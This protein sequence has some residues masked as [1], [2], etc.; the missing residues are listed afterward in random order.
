[1]GKG[2]GR[3]N[4]LERKPGMGMEQKGGEDTPPASRRGAT[5]PFWG[6]K[7]TGYLRAP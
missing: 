5:P 6:S 1:M 7:P 4:E 3:T 2:E